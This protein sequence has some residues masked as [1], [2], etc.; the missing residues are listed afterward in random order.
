MIPF[1]REHT[2]SLFIKVT[3]HEFYS[4]WLILGATLLQ[5]RDVLFGVPYELIRTI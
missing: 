5:Q 4:L 3:V 2:H 1:H